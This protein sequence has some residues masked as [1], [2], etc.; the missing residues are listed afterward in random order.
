VTFGIANQLTQT[1]LTTNA[2]I[3]NSGYGL[4]VAIIGLVDNDNIVDLAFGLPFAAAYSGGPVSGAVYIALMEGGFGVRSSFIIPQKNNILDSPSLG[5]PLATGSEFG[6]SL[7]PA[8]DFNADGVPDIIVGAPGVSSNS[9][10]AYF[11]MLNRAGAVSDYALIPCTLL[12]ECGSG[13]NVGSSVFYRTDLTNSFYTYLAIIGAENKS[14]P[15]NV[16]QGEVLL[17]DL[18]L[19]SPSPTPSVSASPS[20]SASP[21]RAPTIS[22]SPTASPS[23]PP[24]AVKPILPFLWNEKCY[25]DSDSANCGI[26]IGPGYYPSWTPGDSAPRLNYV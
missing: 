7:A 23:P 18:A 6:Y 16:K 25:R 3:P 4:S 15:G 20:A 21:S 9:G 12:N 10:A 1:E 5:G 13:Q 2:V 26:G 19:A 17:I 14:T 8:G 22:P 11:I 24:P